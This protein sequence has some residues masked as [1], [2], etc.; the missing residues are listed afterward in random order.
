MDEH[1]DF[2]NG[3]AIVLTGVSAGGMG[4]FF[5]SNHLVENT[6]KAKI[7]SIPDSG[8]FLVDFYSELAHAQI[9]KDSARAIML[10]VNSEQDAFPIKK[11]FDDNR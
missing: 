8:V 4:T 7:Y 1:F 3:E 10:L 5:Y 6:K 2:Y 11:C 9:L